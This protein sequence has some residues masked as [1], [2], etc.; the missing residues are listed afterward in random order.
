MQRY[1]NGEAIEE[2][3]K[4]TSTIYQMTL[5]GLMLPLRWHVVA[6]ALAAACFL[7]LGHPEVA[8]LG[9]AACCAFDAAH[10]RV[11]RHWMA[12]S[13]GVDVATG[14]RQ[15]AAVSAARA[16]VYMAPSVFLALSG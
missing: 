16:C 15:L 6:N 4:V 12:T 11:V 10:G 7:A 14:F 8:M 1:H 13:K 3:P 9:F 5:A 2:A